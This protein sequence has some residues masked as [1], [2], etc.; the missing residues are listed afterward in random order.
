MSANDGLIVLGEA[1]QI[2]EQDIPT[3]SGVI[4][5]IS[6][7]LAEVDSLI[8]LC[9]S[10]SHTASIAEIMSK[11][12]TTTSVGIITITATV[13]STVILTLSGCLI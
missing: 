2:I 8:N 1:S 10:S 11:A 6:K 9:P 13:T 7:A 5:I 12:Y 4:H 3:A